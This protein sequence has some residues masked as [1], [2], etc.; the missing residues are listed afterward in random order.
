MCSYSVQALRCWEQRK[1]QFPVCWL[2][3]LEVCVCERAEVCARVSWGRAGWGR[4]SPSPGR[5]S[6]GGQLMGLC[7]T[8]SQ[9]P[10]PDP[11][12]PTHTPRHPQHGRGSSS[13]GQK[14]GPVAR[15]ASLSSPSSA[16]GHLPAVWSLPSSPR[17]SS[18]VNVKPFFSLCGQW[19]PREI[20]LLTQVPE[21]KGKSQVGLGPQTG[22]GQV[23]G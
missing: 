11:A 16:R 20:Q 12:P 14:Q 8:V 2:G 1:H 19:F 15:Q 3:L 17:A 7:S 18:P 23:G 10:P 13:S 22:L 9:T 5:A 21:K 6:L 4:A